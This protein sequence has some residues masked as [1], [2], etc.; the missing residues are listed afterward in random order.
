[1]EKLF[2]MTL[3]TLFFGVSAYGETKK[4]PV[5]TTPEKVNTKTAVTF[6]D[7]TAGQ[8][9][10]QTGPGQYEVLSYK[11]EAGIAFAQ[12]CE[13]SPQKPCKAQD[14]KSYFTKTQ[15]ELSEKCSA[16][17]GE[18]RIARRHGVKKI[19]SVCYFKEDKSFVEL[20]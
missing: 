15:R 14:L 6:P 5:A 1:M 20:N 18:S 7:T 8:I 13:G 16:S 10:I 9:A 19:S 4:I 3:V 11:E 17:L 12:S 2:G